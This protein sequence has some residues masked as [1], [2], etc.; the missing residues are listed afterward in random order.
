MRRR[1]AHL[2]FLAAA[3]IGSAAVIPSACGEQLPERSF[4]DSTRVLAVQVKVTQPLVP[5]PPDAATRCE[6][7][8]G[9]VV[10]L[11]PFIVNAK[12]PVKVGLT[13]PVWIACQAHAGQ[14]TF[15]CIK[16]ALPTSLEELPTCAA[17]LDPSANAEPAEEGSAPDFPAPHSPCLIPTADPNFAEYQVPFS[18][19]AFLGGNIEVTMVGSTPGGTPT[20]PCADA[21]L[22]GRGE[23][24]HDCL[25]AVQRVEIG[26]VGRLILM[27]K[28]LGL[29]LGG[30]QPP[31]PED[32]PDADRNPRMVSM[33]VQPADIAGNPAGEPVEVPYGGQIDVQATAN[34]LLH[35]T[36]LEND[37]QTY[38]MVVD[39]TET[40]ERDEAYHTHWFRSWGLLNTSSSDDPVSHNLWILDSENPDEPDTPKDNIA[41][42]YYVI[43]DGRGGTD[44]WWFRA[45]VGAP[46]NN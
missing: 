18:A 14:N 6:A 9:E 38:P 46:P 29:D 22:A 32:I 41:T 23:V 12:G 5:D 20:R 34:I 13:D 15:G 11:T 10:R 3:S 30:L 42:L 33:T 25:M 21:L 39:E 27:A 8:P 43:R 19:N 37:L 16:A 2:G 44:W 24:P 4:V 17:D 35:A 36:A 26:P 7:L 31:N 40:S 1:H 28:A 45:N